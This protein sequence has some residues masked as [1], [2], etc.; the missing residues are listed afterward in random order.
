MIRIGTIVGSWG[1][2]GEVK[3]RP[4]GAPPEAGLETVF[5]R[6]G[7]RDEAFRVEALKAAGA[8][9][10]FKLRGIDTMDAAERLR[11]CP[12]LQPEAALP[13]PGPDAYYLYQLVGCRVTT[14]DGRELGTVRD[15]WTIPGN[16]QLVVDRDGR[17]LL[18]PLSRA[19]CR[20]VDVAAKHILVEVPEGLLDLNEI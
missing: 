20:R 3:Y 9:Y 8:G 6:V 2:K 10:R 12:V 5:I 19:I 17:D 16:D 11:G 1:N 18:L 7:G 15:V 13:P 4:D 14:G